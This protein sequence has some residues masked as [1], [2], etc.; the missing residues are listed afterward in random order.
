MHDVGYFKTE[1]FIHDALLRCAEAM[2]EELRKE[3][4]AKRKVETLAVSWPSEHITA[5]DGVKV[6]HAVLMPLPATFTESETMAALKRLVEKTK[7]YG[8]ALVEQKDEQLRVLFETH[9][10][11]RAWLIPLERHGDIKVPGK[12]VVR[13]NTECLGLLWQARRGTS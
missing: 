2:A 12:T 5:D 10:G 8:L 13:D 1:L 11:A 9:H 7:A 4:G 3:W 6:T